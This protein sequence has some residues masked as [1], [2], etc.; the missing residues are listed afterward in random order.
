MKL[1][2]D[3]NQD[4]QLQAIKS[5]VDIFEGQPLSQSDLKILY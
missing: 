2:F 3:P 5:V 1:H 4:Y